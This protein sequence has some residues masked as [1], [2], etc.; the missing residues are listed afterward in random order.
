MKIEFLN[1]ISDNG[2][3]EHAV[4]EELIRL[5]DFDQIQANLFRN[6]I[7]QT[8]IENNRSLNVNQIDFITAINCT[9]TL[10]ISDID[11]GISSNDNLS[12]FCDL[13][14]LS[15]E[16]M[17]H[18]IE[19]FCKEECGGYQWLYDVDTPIEFLFS[20]GGGW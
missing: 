19:P 5:Y 15:Y 1:N 9:L 7:Q 17:T 8:I 3:F 13:T 4:T 2:K 11:H 18:L 12:F 20:P 16:N 10:R 6:A 14:L